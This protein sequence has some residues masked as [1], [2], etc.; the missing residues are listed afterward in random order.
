[1]SRL[2]FYPGCLIQ[3]R[4]PEYERAA[5]SVLNALGIELE[6]VPETVCCGGPIAESFTA[7]WVY[8]SIYNLAR[9]AHLGHDTVVTLCGSCTN[10]LTR[11]AQLLATPETSAEAARRLEPL[12]LSAPGHIEV[13]HLLRVLAD[14]EQELR[15]RIVRPLMLRV[16]LN[17]PCRFFGPVR[18]WL[19]M[20]RC[21]RR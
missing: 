18:R 14:H 1:M 7:D 19:S 3:Q 5:R 10:A 20:T 6:I 4:I 2:A 12:G 17:N 9:A 16:A 8:L 21:I 15:D 11:A 13:Y